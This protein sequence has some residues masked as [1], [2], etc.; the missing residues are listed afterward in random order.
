[1]SCADIFHLLFVGSVL[2][3]SS[4]LSTNSWRALTVLILLE[5]GSGCVL[6]LKILLN[7]GLLIAILVHVT[8]KWPIYNWSLSYFLCGRFTGLIAGINDVDPVRWPGSKWKCLLVWDCGLSNF[9]FWQYGLSN[10][11]NVLLFIFV[12]LCLEMSAS[13]CFEL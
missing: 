10:F 6:K 11:N 3:N 4:Y 2:R 5:W 12:K 1:M 7:E 13:V 8:Y 9:F